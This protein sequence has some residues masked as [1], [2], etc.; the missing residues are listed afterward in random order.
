[1]KVND[2]WPSERPHRPLVVA[3]ERQVLSFHQFSP[4]VCDDAA[5]KHQYLKRICSQVTCLFVISDVLLPQ[6]MSL[7]LSSPFLF[8]SHFL[9][10]RASL[11]ACSILV[12]ICIS[13]LK[14]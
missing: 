11:R 13:L 9:L 14:Y 10:A 3:V 6:H 8:P 1:M 2:L 12:T 4:D 7:L 5:G